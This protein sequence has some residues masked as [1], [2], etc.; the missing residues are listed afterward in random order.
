MDIASAGG[1]AYA[2]VQALAGAA[3]VI[4]AILI[5]LAM[6]LSLIHI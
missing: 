5:A 6:M 4:G 2:L 3:V 1:A